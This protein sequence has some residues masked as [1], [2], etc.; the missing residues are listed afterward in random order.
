MT[1][2]LITGRINTAPAIKTPSKAGIDS[3]KE[4]PVKSAGTD[5]SITITAL[6]QG[7]QKVLESTSSATSVDVDRVAA[8]KKALDDGSYQVNGERIASKMIQ[9]EKLMPQDN[10]I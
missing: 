2:E 8:V 3:G 9:Y 5:D 1:M 10:V 4:A 6:A 7:I